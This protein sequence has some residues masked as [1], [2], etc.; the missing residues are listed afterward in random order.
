MVHLAVDQNTIRLY[1]RRGLERK[2]KVCFLSENLSAFWHW[3]WSE[4]MLYVGVLEIEE[5]VSVNIVNIC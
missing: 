3:K 4:V 5:N 1:L 2:N